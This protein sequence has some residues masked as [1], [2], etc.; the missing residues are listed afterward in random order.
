MTEPEE[1]PYDWKAA[2]FC[3]TLDDAAGL[4]QSTPQRVVDLM[5]TGQ[6][7]FYMKADPEREGGLPV[8]CARFD[9]ED[10]AEFF[11]GEHERYASIALP[12]LSNLRQYL[13]EVPRTRDYETAVR[14]KRPIQTRAGL[15]VQ[16]D[17]VV[18]FARRVS[19]GPAAQMKNSTETAFERL[20][21]TRVRS[22]TP[23][24]ERQRW[25]IWY[26]LPEV[27][28]FEGRL[29]KIDSFLRH[30]GT[31]RADEEVIQAGDGSGPVVGQPLTG[32][33]E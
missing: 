28:A 5:L 13:R 15:H 2:T 4:L 32:D 6:I 3:L 30:D 31:V 16:T 26:R 24:G 14:G 22:L 17:A 19:A 29:V 12:V 10:L 25:A 23:Y 20:G 1:K 11:R 7:G 27:I 8:D 9:P 18:E 21:L 33:F